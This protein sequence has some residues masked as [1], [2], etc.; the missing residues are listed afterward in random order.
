MLCWHGFRFSSSAVPDIQPKPKRETEMLKPTLNTGNLPAE[1]AK[2]A[3][4][5]ASKTDFEAPKCEASERWAILG[6]KVKSDDK[7]KAETQD[8]IVPI[9]FAV[10]LPKLS[11]ADVSGDDWQRFTI[12][13]A[14]DRQDFVLKANAD[15]K[16]KVNPLDLSA[17]IADYFDT[18]RGDSSRKITLQWFDDVFT[19]AFVLRIEQRN[20]MPEFAKMSKDQMAKKLEDYKD[21]LSVLC[22]NDKAAEKC[23]RHYV[24]GLRQTTEKL[25]ELGFLSEDEQTEWIIARC[26]KIEGIPE[27]DDIV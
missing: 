24:R 3:I 5:F 23:S 6:Y 25:M 15:K 26:E 1:L 13:L 12:A 17:V 14:E 10:K 21:L 19:A 20:L 18:S 22:G 7:K 27:D 2:T 11:P 16:S 9:S 8:V 4:S